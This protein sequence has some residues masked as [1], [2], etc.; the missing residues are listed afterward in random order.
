MF[1]DRGVEIKTPDQLAAM[2]RA[3]LVVG[4]T[5]ELVQSAVGPGVTTAELDALAE[6]H[7]RDLGAVPSFKGYHGF[8]GSLC[9][10]VNDQVV[11]GIPGPLVLDEGDLVS[12]DCGAIVAGWHGDAATSAVLGSPDETA[13]EVEVLLRVTEDALW[14]GIAAVQAGGRLTDVCAAVEAHVRSASLPLGIVEDYV[15]H[16]IGSQMHQPPSVPNTGRAGRGPR[17]VPGMAI[18]IEPMITLGSPETSVLADDWTVVCSDGSWAAHFEHTV[19]VTADGP[20]V[21][22][23]LDGGQQRLDDLGVRAGGP[24]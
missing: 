13:T 15:G 18:A 8:P 24:R 9:I 11:H 2:R 23:A 17:L 21:L 6:E 10:S 20:W 22:T 3:G 16:G 14:R 19:A 1:R 5:L 12:V 7:I 4:R